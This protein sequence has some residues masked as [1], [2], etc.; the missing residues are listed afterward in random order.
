VKKTAGVLLP[1]ILASS[2]SA[3][4]IKEIKFENLVRVS[5]RIALE[6]LGFKIGD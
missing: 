4:Q 2:L 5:E 1:F 6:T 3:T